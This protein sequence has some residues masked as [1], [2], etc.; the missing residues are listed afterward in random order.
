MKITSPNSGI[1]FEFNDDI[2]VMLSE[3][4]TSFLVEMPVNE[5]IAAIAYQLA[6][7][8]REIDTPSQHEC[9]DAVKADLMG[10]VVL[11]IVSAGFRAQRKLEAE[12]VGDAGSDDGN[13]ACDA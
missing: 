2:A 4:M 10:Q 9:L 7:A 12:L 13:E 6:L 3:E 11:Q 5:R 1:S 8:V